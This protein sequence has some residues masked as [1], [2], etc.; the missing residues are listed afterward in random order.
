MPATPDQIR[1]AVW[2]A[3]RRTLNKFRENPY[4][5]FTESDIHSYLYHCLHS[6]H[7]EI[8]RENRRIYLVHREYPTNFRYS[9]EALLIADY[10]EPYPLNSRQGDRGELR[11]R[12]HQSPVRNQRDKHRGHC[13]CS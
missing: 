3:I 9:K 7:F 8:V 12:R 5:F 13:Q 11:H 6:S 10:Y 1:T 4:Y 2:N